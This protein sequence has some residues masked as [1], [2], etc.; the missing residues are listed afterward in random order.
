MPEAEI[1]PIQSHSAQAVTL[2]SD[3]SFIRS[4]SQS[5]EV[6]LS[7]AFLDFLKVFC[8][9]LIK[10]LLSTFALIRFPSTE[11][12]SRPKSST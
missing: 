1:L 9:V 6:R 11:K 12:P 4:P 8:Q 2:L 7:E 10:I 5:G 3:L